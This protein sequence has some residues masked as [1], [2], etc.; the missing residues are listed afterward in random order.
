MFFNDLLII[1]IVIIT[2]NLF[3]IIITNLNIKYFRLKYTESQSIEDLW[4]IIPVVFLIFIGFPRI[5]NLYICEEFSECDLSI[6]IVGHQWYWSYDL[7]N[8]NNNFDSIMNK[9][10]FFFRLLE[11]YNHLII[12][13]KCSIRF[14]ISSEDVIHSWTIP[15]IGIKIDATPGRISQVITL[16]NRPGILVGQCREICGANHSFIP[17]FIS[18]NSINNFLK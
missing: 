12:P 10:K 15:S 3:Y 7:R 9:E 18:A 2:V 1:L 16:I 5:K 14:L 11:T 4:L 17:I 8:L 13:I 6:K